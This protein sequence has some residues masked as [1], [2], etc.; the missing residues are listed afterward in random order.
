MIDITYKKIIH[1]NIILGE[2][3]KLLH[4]SQFCQNY[5]MV[6]YKLFNGNGGMYEK[7]RKK[8]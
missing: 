8:E 3:K 5:D 4:Y 7:N 2:N 1:I 6:G